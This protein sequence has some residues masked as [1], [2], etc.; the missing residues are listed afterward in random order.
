MPHTVYQQNL[1]YQQFQKIFCEINL[2]FFKIAVQNH[3]SNFTRVYSCE[4]CEGFQ[5]IKKELR[6]FSL[7]GAYTYINV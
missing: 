2:F 1:N 7:L 3:F 4:A 5:P 6:V